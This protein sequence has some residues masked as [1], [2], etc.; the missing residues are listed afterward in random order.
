MMSRAARASAAAAALLFA[1]A[2]RAEDHLRPEDSILSDGGAWRD[3]DSIVVGVLKEAYTGNVVARMTVLPAFG[4]EYAVALKRDDG[5]A[6]AILV[7]APAVGLH[8][9]DALAGAVADGDAKTVAELRKTLPA[10]WHDVKVARCAIALDKPRA[11]RLVDI[12]TRALLKTHYDAPDPSGI[13]TVGADGVEYHFYSYGKAGQAWSPGGEAGA[14]VDIG[15][16]MAEYCGKKT[17]SSLA[18]L[19]ALVETSLPAQE[20]K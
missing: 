9:Y 2:A 10:D 19:D 16:A 8:D 7:V 12:W 17:K 5:G 3:Y 6:Y 1:T 14:L 18:A 4:P 15:D 20:K 13:E 11:E